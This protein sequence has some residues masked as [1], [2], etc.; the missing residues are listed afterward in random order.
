MEGVR[1]GEGCLKGKA[2]S[3]YCSPF[4][5]KKFVQKLFKSF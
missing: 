5:F 1:W 2:K 4:L 3:Q